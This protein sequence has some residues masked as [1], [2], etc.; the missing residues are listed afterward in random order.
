MTGQA[1]WYDLRVRIEPAPAEEAGVSAPQL[2]VLRPPPGLG[3]R[4]AEVA[5]GARFGG[6]SGR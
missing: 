6:D 5:Y 1:A 3:P 2:P 4:P